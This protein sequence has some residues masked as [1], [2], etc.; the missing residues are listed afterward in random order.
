MIFVLSMSLVL[1]CV[2]S[3]VVFIFQ[4]NAKKILKA[5]LCYYRIDSWIP[6]CGSISL[7]LDLLD[8][9]PER[10][11][12]PAVQDRPGGSS[13]P[14][15]LLCSFPRRSQATLAW[16]ELGG[17]LRPEQIHRCVTCVVGVLLAVV[18][19]S[20]KSRWNEIKNMDKKPVYK[21]SSLLAQLTLRS[22]R[23]Q[24]CSHAVFC[25]IKQYIF[26]KW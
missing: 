14:F 10:S 6:D 4:I 9:D 20:F 17:P 19:N 21:D 3:I 26:F 24:R 11:R 18:L 7:S 25:F 15:L 23:H 16:T 2:I 22:S 1:S 5:F 13:T 8:T 12:S